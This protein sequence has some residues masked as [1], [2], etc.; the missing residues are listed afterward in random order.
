MFPEDVITQL[1][2]EHGL[3]QNVPLAPF[4]TFKVGGPARYFVRAKSVHTVQ[5]VIAAAQ[6]HNVPWY[7]LGGGSNVLVHD[8][9]FAG[10]VIKLELNALDI[11]DQTVTVG[12]GMLLSAVIMRTTRSGLSGL[13]FAVG[14]PASVGGAVWANLGCRGSEIAN[15]LQSV[16]VLK[17]SGEVVVLSREQCQ[18]GYR[19]SIFKHQSATEPWIILS[20][21]FSLIAADPTALRTTVLDLTKLKKEEQ[22]VGDNTAGCAFRNPA[23]SSQKASQL[24]DELG[25]KGFRIGDAMVS[26]KHANFIV[27]TGHATADHIVQLISYIKQQVR[28][29]A[30]VQLMEEIEYVGF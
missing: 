25:L 10:V 24:I 6:Q 4:T 14:V 3:E 11:T 2:A 18:F 7:P 28:D 19:E 22:N 23:D 5:A 27:N 15:V 9:G 17:P 29:T 1:I 26:T 30:G 13:E 21:T 20:A 8:N 12:A 16:E